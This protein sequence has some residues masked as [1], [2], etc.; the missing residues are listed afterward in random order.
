MR[1]LLAIIGAVIG[2]VAA[3]LTL[4]GSVATWAVS[5]FS[6]ESPDQVSDAHVAVFMGVS[7]LGL[8]LGWVLGYAI[9]SAFGGSDAD[10]DVPDQ[11]QT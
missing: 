6:F 3:T 8:A 9:G 4:S 1:Y 5:R 2:A 7:V 11:E 10:L